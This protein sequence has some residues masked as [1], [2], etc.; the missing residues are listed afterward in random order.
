MFLME[1]IHVL[2]EGWLNLYGAPLAGGQVECG[3]LWSWDPPNL[4][5]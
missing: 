2:L 3:Y 1:A 5:G 4:F